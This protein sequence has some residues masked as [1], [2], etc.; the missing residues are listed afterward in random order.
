M[1]N[2]EAP[3]RAEP[4][5]LTEIEIAQAMR[6][7][8]LYDAYWTWD[9]DL[10]VARAIEKKRDAQWR[11]LLAAERERCAKAGEV[12]E[13]WQLVPKEATPEMCR[14]AVIFA[15]GNAVYRNVAAEALRIEESIYGE[16]YAAMLAA[17]PTQRSPHEQE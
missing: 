2:S 3:E 5:P 8:G 13:G 9:E 1:S 12:P 10:L 4:K 14:A 15:N 6:D 16:A 17:A 11:A 7:G